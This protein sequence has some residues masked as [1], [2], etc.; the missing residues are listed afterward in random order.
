[1][2]SVGIHLHGYECGM[3]AKQWSDNEVHACVCVWYVY[4]LQH[5]EIEKN[6]TTTFKIGIFFNDEYQQNTSERT[7]ELTNARGILAQ[8]NNIGSRA[9]RFT[10]F[11]VIAT[12]SQFHY[13]LP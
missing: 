13:V 9:L 4:K 1:M 6:S 8:N 12:N 11:F 5:Q 10:F 3:R 7:N 2:A